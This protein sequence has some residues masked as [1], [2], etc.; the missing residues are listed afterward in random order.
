M[1]IVKSFNGSHSTVKTATKKMAAFHYF[2]SSESTA[3][4]ENVDF[5]WII[6]YLYIYIIKLLLKF[7]NNLVLGNPISSPHITSTQY[8]GTFARTLM[9]L[10]IILWLVLRNSY[11]G[12]LYNYLQ[13]HRL[14]SSFDTIEKIQASNCKIIT[15]VSGYML[16]LKDMFSLDRWMNCSTVHNNRW[17]I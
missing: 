16:F 11:Q 6:Y 1:R 12:A 7:R 9:L 5:R 3:H 10:W 15:T 2:G 14:S 13:S 17:L 8:F 4:F